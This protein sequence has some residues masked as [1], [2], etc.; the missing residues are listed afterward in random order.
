MRPSLFRHPSPRWFVPVLVG[1]GVAMMILSVPVLA[2]VGPGADPSRARLGGDGTYRG[3]L[4]ANAFSHPMANLSFADR[5]QFNIGNAI[6]RRPWVS[7][8]AS[9]RSA[10]GLGP[11]YNARA[12]QDCHLK[13]GRG[14]PPEANFP[15]D[16][17]LSMLMRLSVPPRTQAER[18]LIDSGRAAALPDP[19]YGG[20]LQDFALPSHA[21]EGRIHIAWTE[22]AIAFS[23]GERVSLRRPAVSITDLGYGPTDPD[24]MM[25]LR[26][27]P[28]MIGLGLLEAIPEAAILALADPQDADG[29]GISGRANRVWSRE[30]GDFAL[31]RFGWKATEPTLN[32]QNLG[33]FAGDIGMSSTLV[34]AAWGDCTEAQAACRAG[35]H[36][37]DDRHAVEIA[38]TLAEALL[39]YT[40][41]LAVPARRD[42]DDPSVRNG[43]ALFAAA[44]CAACHTPSFETAAD[45]P[46]AALAGQ[47]IWPYSDLLLHD[48]GDGLADNR[49]VARAG[50]R[51]WRTPPLWGIGLTQTVSGH[52]YFLHDG[53]ARS[54]TEAILWHGG[55]AEAAR[56]AF[57]TMPATDRT[58]LLRF[59]ESL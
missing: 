20:Q 27:A 10:D 5:A 40:Q 17:A 12:C 36:G 29:D 13:D 47:R 42:I 59:L 19:V 11:L 2:G 43:E 15:D 44:G 25:S 41:T 21:I 39:F 38:D 30:A 31:G 14:H 23:D 32:Q 22:E 48:M 54:L 3:P 6:F 8:P 26:V 56:E 33:A 4:S 57:R 53:R 58:D 55:E 34:P 18:A 45:A 24:L 28:A 35:P 52:T 51:E 49:P 16:I 9:T 7:A 46:L 37:I 50:G 1:A